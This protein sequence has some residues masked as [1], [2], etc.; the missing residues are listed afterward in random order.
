MNDSW[1]DGLRLKLEAFVDA[2][3]V[4]GAKQRLRRHRRRDRKPPNRL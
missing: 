1:R 3:V 4:N 2:M